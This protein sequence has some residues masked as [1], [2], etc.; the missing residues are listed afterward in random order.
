MGNWWRDEVVAAGKL[1]LAICLAAFIL[2]FL[3]TRVIT[4]MIRAGRGPFRDNVSAS[5]THVHHA[6]PGIVLLVLGALMSLG[7]DTFESPWIEISAVLVGSG[8]S[9]VLDEFALILHLHDVYW[10]NEGRV[11]VEMIGLTGACLGFVLLGFSP[12][13]D[14]DLD[15]EAFGIRVAV[16]SGLLVHALF[17]LV[18]VFKGKYRAALIGC[19]VPFVVWWCAA[20]LARPTSWWARHLYGARRRAK[21]LA[22]AQRFDARWDPRWRWLSDVIAGSPSRPDLPDGTLP[23]DPVTAGQ[24][25]V[26][27]PA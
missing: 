21:A 3:T 24:E 25:P 2:T 16:I 10:E 5:G 6:V 22:R 12:L 20:R 27:D 9:L 15:A 17:V 11:S 8:A 19:F 26:T 18:C 4:R 13:G 1:P 23:S 7:L 14:V